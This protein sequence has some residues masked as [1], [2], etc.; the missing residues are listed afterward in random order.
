MEAYV[1]L[2]RRGGTVLLD[3]LLAA[4]A[5]VAFVAAPFLAIAVVYGIFVLV[6]YAG[7]LL[8][9]DEIHWRRGYG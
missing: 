6:D 8:R 1:L 5:I 7:Q 4:L 3:L 9:H 2:T